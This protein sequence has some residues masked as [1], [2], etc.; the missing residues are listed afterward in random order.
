MG[1]GPVVDEDD[2]HRDQ[3]SGDAFVPELGFDGASQAW[4]VFL[5]GDIRKSGN[6]AVSQLLGFQLY[7]S[8]WY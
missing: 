6:D 2:P 7:L 3:R 5:R 1:F 8:E 4:F